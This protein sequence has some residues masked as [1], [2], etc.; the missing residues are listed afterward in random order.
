MDAWKYKFIYRVVQNISLVRFAHSCDILVNTLTRIILYFR[1]NVVN[2]A[3]F[4]VIRVI[5]CGGSSVE[6][7]LNSKYNALR[8]LRIRPFCHSVLLYA[9]GERHCEINVFFKVIKNEQG[10]I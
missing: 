7:K 1:S 4:S 9:T 3:C 5:L 6:L 2:I 10:L 8:N